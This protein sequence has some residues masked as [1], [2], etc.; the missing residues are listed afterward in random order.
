[1]EALS[2]S[3]IGIKRYCYCPRWYYINYLL[4]FNPKTPVKAKFIISD[5]LQKALLTRK[6]A[7]FTERCNDLA[8]T[9]EIAEEKVDLKEMIARGELLVSEALRWISNIKNI[10]W[11]EQLV[12]GTSE[13]FKNI[14]FETYPKLVGEKQGELALFHF[15]IA[16]D[17]AHPMDTLGY[18]YAAAMQTIALKQAGIDIKKN[19]LVSCVVRARKERHSSRAKTPIVEV[20]EEELLMNPKFYTEQ[21]DNIL[22]NIQHNMENKCFPALGVIDGT[23]IWCPNGRIIQNKSLCEYSDDVLKQFSESS[24][25]R[26]SIERWRDEF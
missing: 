24:L 26:T 7:D 10:A 12:K 5:A 11:Q 19:I 22:E 6:L 16:Y 4:G 14:T 1:M 8:R 18:Y 2:I 13:K 3:D 25:Q 9:E 20:Q 17:V 23:C 21:I 15:R